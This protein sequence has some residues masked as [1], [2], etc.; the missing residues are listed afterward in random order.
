M[1]LRAVSLCLFLVLLFFSDLRA[2]TDQKKVLMLLWRGL[3]ATEAAFVNHLDRLGEVPTYTIINGNQDRSRLADKLRLIQA[4]LKA[5]DY[6]VIY[7][8]GTTVTTMLKQVNRGSTPVVFNIVYDPVGAGIVDSMQFPG[9]NT[10]GVTNGVPIDEQLDTFKRVTP[11]NDMVLLYTVREQ[12]ANILA[13][14]VDA[15]AREKE[16][17]LT[18]IRVAPGTDAVDSALERIRS[19]EIPCQMLYAGADTYLASRAVDIETSIGDK[20]LLYGGTATFVKKGWLGAYAAPLDEMGRFSAVKVKQVLNGDD[21]GK[22]PVSLPEPV[23][24]LSQTKLDAFELEPPQGAV[25]R[26]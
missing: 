22:I 18:R 12:N 11:F 17:N 4:E 26:P 23:V 9:H 15:W 14:E 19:G 2:A 25:I 6:D 24:I 1:N 13:A 8:Y 5:G 20:V 10:T 16:V 21:A 3:T 7:S